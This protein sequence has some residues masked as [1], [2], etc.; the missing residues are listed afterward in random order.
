[1]NPGEGLK[2]EDQRDG[3]EKGSEEPREELD[4]APLASDEEETE[5]SRGVC[6][7]VHTKLTFEDW[8]DFPNGGRSLP[9]VLA[10][11]ELHVEQRHPRDDEEKNVGDEEGTWGGGGGGGG[12]I[13]HRYITFPASRDLWCFFCFCFVAYSENRLRMLYVDDDEEGGGVLTC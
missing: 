8:A 10:Q 3:N 9:V 13:T 4:R 11:G 2:G 5:T 1:V 12:I 6:V 7:P